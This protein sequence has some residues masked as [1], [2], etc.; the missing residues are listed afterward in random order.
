MDNVIHCLVSRNCFFTEQGAIATF[1]KR[2]G[3]IAESN[4]KEGDTLL[5][6]EYVKILYASVE[7]S[8]KGNFLQKMRIPYL[9]Y[10]MYMWTSEIRKEMTFWHKEYTSEQIIIFVKVYA[11]ILLFLKKTFLLRFFNSYKETLVTMLED[12]F[13]MVKMYANK[14]NKEGMLHVSLKDL[15]DHNLTLLV[16]ESLLYELYKDEIID[17]K[18]SP[19]I[20][21]R[22]WLYAMHNAKSDNRETLDLCLRFFHI[23]KH[24]DEEKKILDRFEKEKQLVNHLTNNNQFVKTV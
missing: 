11:K 21:D 12:D 15:G 5:A 6:I 20:S 16:F 10:R 22:L 17:L 19:D 23:T 9:C 18:N 3:Y 1:E 24:Y 8:E 4:M 2:Y 13:D 14:E 7:F